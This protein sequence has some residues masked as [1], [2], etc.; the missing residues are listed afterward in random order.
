LTASIVIATFGSDHYRE[1][2][3]TRAYP[4]A[5]GQGALEVIL[6]HDEGGK[7]HQARNNAAAKAKGEFLVF[8]D[9]DD[10]LEAGYIAAMLSAPGPFREA[11][12][13]YPRVRYVP[14]GFAGPDLPEAKILEK[15]HLFRGNYMVI[16]TM[17]K[18]DFFNWIGGFDEFQSW[19]DWA[20]WIK[21]WLAGAQTTLVPEAIYRIHR[22]P[23]GRCV[24]PNGRQLFDQIVDLYTPLA[25]AK[26][27]V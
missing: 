7:I 8:L 4:S 11:D 9:A 15:K 6:H 27:L 13:R 23:N 16:G 3:R 25:R 24:V 10:E 14:E 19:E 22:N 26:G 12:L 1:L 18:R 21:C 20:L 17:V 5:I 2:A